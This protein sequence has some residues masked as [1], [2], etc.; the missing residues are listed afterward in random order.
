M[1]LR[2]I[3]MQW[4]PSYPTWLSWVAASQQSASALEAIP[5]RP[6]ATVVAFR[7]AP[8]DAPGDTE[9]SAIFSSFSTKEKVSHFMD[10]IPQPAILHVRFDKKSSRIAAD[11]FWL[12]P[13]Q[14]FLS[15]TAPCPS[16][17]SG[18]IQVSGTSHL[19]TPSRSSTSKTDLNSTKQSPLGNTHLKWLSVSGDLQSYPAIQICSD[20]KCLISSIVWWVKHQN[21]INGYLTIEFERKEV[22]FVT[23]S[24]FIHHF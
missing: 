22:W 14:A 10:S 17:L 1:R 23:F 20:G 6:W 7:S 3:L 12:I 21:K 24:L 19:S 5:G 4:S 2:I 13:A 15:T 18:P 11:T 9:R 16:P 8:N